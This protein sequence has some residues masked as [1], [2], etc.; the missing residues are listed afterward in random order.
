MDLLRITQSGIIDQFSVWQ[1]YFNLQDERLVISEAA[2]KAH[3]YDTLGAETMQDIN[4]I[5]N[6]LDPLLNPPKN[7]IISINR[8]LDRGHR[9]KDI[10]VLLEIG[11][12]TLIKS[13]GK[14]VG[15]HISTY[16]DKKGYLKDLGV[17][18]N[19]IESIGVIALLEKLERLSLINVGMKELGPH[20]RHLK[21]LKTLHITENPISQLSDQLGELKNLEDLALDDNQF[22]EVP[23]VIQKLTNLRE[24]S[25][26]GNP[27]KSLPE[28]LIDMKNLRM[29]FIDE[30][31]FNGKFESSPFATDFDYAI[32]ILDRD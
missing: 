27:L 4:L 20:V 21:S 7:W 6:Y 18:E 25:L 31:F 28:W 19:Q 17:G 29:I 32:N 11:S 30:N 24:L 12:R 5:N 10:H 15:L 13:T 26:R 23:P 14:P 16:F 22:I 8:M 1:E 9:I 2:I 3:I